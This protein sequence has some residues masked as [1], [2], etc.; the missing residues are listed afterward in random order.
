[1]YSTLPDL[2]PSSHRKAQDFSWDVFPEDSK[3]YALKKSP[4]RPQMK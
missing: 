1:M 3:R 2:N 4:L